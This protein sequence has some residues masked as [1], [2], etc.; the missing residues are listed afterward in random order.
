MTATTDYHLG[1]GQQGLSKRKTLNQLLNPSTQ[2]FLLA[3]GLSEGMTVLDIGCGIGA[4]SCWLAEQVGPTGN[5]IAIDNSPAQ[6]EIAREIA[7]EQG[8]DNIEFMQLSADQLDNIKVR[9]DLVYCRFLLIHLINPDEVVQ[10]IYNHLRPGGVFACES[11][12]LGHEFCFPYNDAF[13]KWRQLNFEVFKAMG[14][15]PQTGKKIYNM[16]HSAGFESLSA[17]LFQPILTTAEQ[18]HEMLV[19]DLH[20]QS[21]VFVQFELTDTVEMETVR[22]ELTELAESEKYFIAYCQSCQVAGLKPE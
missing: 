5:V 22:D 13:D 20:E 8:L 14:K 15:D 21:D 19:N 18:R 6:L 10:S 3:S 7:Q 12:I 11:A 17:R 16:M 1:V 4:M 2:Q 9:F